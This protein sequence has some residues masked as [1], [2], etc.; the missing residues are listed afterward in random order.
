MSRAPLSLLSVFASALFLAGARIEGAPIVLG[1]IPIGG[2]GSFDSDNDGGGY[3]LS[4]S[5]TNGTD[6]VSLF[7]S[8]ELF[9]P[10]PAS[11]YNS[12]LC[13]SGPAGLHQV[14]G[15][16]DGV[17]GSGD[18]TTYCVDAYL[19]VYDPTGTTLLASATLTD[20]GVVETGYSAV[21]EGFGNV[22]TSG[23]FVILGAPEPS[24][25]GLCALGALGLVLTRVTKGIRRPLS[26]LPPA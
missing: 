13:G 5:G 10:V 7:V 15:V 9:G 11:I 8:G 4:F 26:R 25:F 14:V 21:N 23:T 22:L 19:D 17:G 2:N 16:I 12:W 24:S 18:Y 3:N 1:P 20:Y 6:T